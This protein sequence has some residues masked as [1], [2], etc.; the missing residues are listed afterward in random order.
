MT[1]N[2][3]KKEKVVLQKEECIFDGAGLKFSL[4][5]SGSSKEATVNY[6]FFWE[7]PLKEFYEIAILHSHIISY[8]R[9]RSTEG[10]LIISGTTFNIRTI[11]KTMGKT[12]GHDRKEKALS[13]ATSGSAARIISYQEA[14]LLDIG[15][16]KLRQLFKV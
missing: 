15:L 14:V 10:N 3:P 11:E 9:D 1:Y 8:L 2:D 7:R 16:H 6:V 4:K 13:I 5:H 12:K